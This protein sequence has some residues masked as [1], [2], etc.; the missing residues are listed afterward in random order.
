MTNQEIRQLF[1]EL[2]YQKEEETIEFKKAEN[3]FNHSDLGNYF[4]ALANETNLKGKRCGWLV[5]GVHDK[6]REIVGT[7]FRNNSEKLQSLKHE[8]AQKTTAAIT[9]SD[10]FEITI[11][12]GGKDK[13]IIIFKIPPAPQGL[14]VAFDGHYFGR[15]GESLVALNI[16]EIIEIK[17]QSVSSD[18]S[19]QIIPQATIA[20]LDEE[21]IHKARFEFK[22]ENPDNASLVDEWDN[23]TFL[24]KAKITINSAITNAALIL[25]GKS[26]NSQLLKPAIAEITW[27][28]KDNNGIEI[29]YK[30]FGMPLLLSVDKLLSRIRNLTFRYMPDNSLFPD[31]AT[32]YDNYVIREAL[33]NCIA[34]QDYALQ[35]R[36][37]VVETPETLTFAN[38]G[39]FIPKTVEAVITQDAPQRFYRNKFL[40]AAMVNLNM[41]DTIGS[42]IKRMYINQRKRFFPLPDYK[43]LENEIAVKI[44][45]KVINPNYVKLLKARSDISL[46]EIVALDLVQKNYPISREMAKILQQKKLI[47]G[48]K[49]NFFLSDTVAMATA[50]MAQYIQ[51]KAFNK[52]YYKDLTIELLKKKKMGAT[53]SEIKEL[54]WNKLS[55]TLNEVQK[56]NYIRN[57]LHEMV[58]DRLIISKYRNYY[59]S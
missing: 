2:R 54:L 4:S 12:E 20:D 52:K 38:G 10:I 13:R 36:I 50:D 39:A 35:E 48:R 49:N 27:I 30:H 51:N 5:F 57:L 14:P 16:Q 3:N 9:F 23:I 47:E 53:K 11:N 21:A 34:H 55:N 18:W 59:L 40:C 26:E 31:E 25:L 56:N 7:S 42:G 17:N 43:I 19:E 28:L 8:I 37:N 46:M 1:D 32:Q 58:K 33:H 22:K 29:D 44:Y 15:D 24:N 6:T 41:I 45:G